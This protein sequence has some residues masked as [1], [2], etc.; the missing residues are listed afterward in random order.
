MENKWNDVKEVPVPK[1]RPFIAICSEGLIGVYSF[2]EHE[3]WWDLFPLRYWA[4]IPDLP[5]GHYYHKDED[6][7]FMV[8]EE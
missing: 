1:D 6:N 4:E 8:Y 2:D 7:G 5:D 3:E